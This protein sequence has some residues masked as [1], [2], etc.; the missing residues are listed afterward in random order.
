MMTVTTETFDPEVVR[1]EQ[2]VLVD[3]WGP[4]CGPCLA[5]MPVVEELAREYDGRLK[6]VKI[7]AQENRKLCARLKV[8]GLPTFL[9]FGR[10]REMGRLTGPI[11][12]DELR[13]WVQRV[14]S[15]ARGIR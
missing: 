5:L 15:R 11:T 1:A 3:F 4:R 12:A 10:G 8:I 7:N 9:F 14:L 13:E 2:P 6:I